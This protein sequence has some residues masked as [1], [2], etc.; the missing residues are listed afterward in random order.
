VDDYALS[1]WVEEIPYRE[2]FV[3]TFESAENPLRSLEGELCT[4]YSTVMDD[5]A[6]ENEAIEDEDFNEEE[7]KEF[8][9]LL[10][11]LAKGETPEALATVE[12]ELAD[13]EP[14][15]RLEDLEDDLE[16]L[17]DL[18]EEGDDEM[19]EDEAWREVAKGVV[20][21][22]GNTVRVGDWN[23]MVPASEIVY[24]TA[25]EQASFDLK[26]AQLTILIEKENRDE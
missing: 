19:F 6:I 21:L 24:G 4:V 3:A 15:D 11:S 18:E 16:E 1:V 8:Q 13:L 25:F 10:E 12:R 23:C 9:D 26:E 14:V 5:E 7:E 20:T 2:E 22:E 17:A